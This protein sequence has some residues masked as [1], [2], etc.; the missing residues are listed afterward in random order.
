MHDRARDAAQQQ[1]LERIE[2]PG[3]D[4]HEVGIPLVGGGNDSG[5]SVLRAFDLFGLGGQRRG[6]PLAG[7]GKNGRR[8]RSAR[9]HQHFGIS[10][11]R[12]DLHRGGRAIQGDLVALGREHASQLVHRGKRTARTVDCNQDFHGMGSSD[13]SRR[14]TTGAA[15]DST[16]RPWPCECHERTCGTRRTWS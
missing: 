10:R 9:P 11:T 14:I 7:F 6:Q 8:Q 3:P 2:P 16:R 1:P 5:A 13:W 12:A 4:R 15:R